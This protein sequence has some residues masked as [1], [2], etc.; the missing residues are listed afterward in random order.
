MKI[1]DRYIKR[2]WFIHALINMAIIIVAFGA[3]MVGFGAF[4]VD[5]DKRSLEKHLTSYAKT[6]SETPMDTLLAVCDGSYTTA[7]TEFDNPGIMFAVYAARENGSFALYTK[8]DFISKTQPVLGGYVNDI[9]EET[10]SGH[11]LLTYTVSIAGSENS[12]VKVFASNEYI[13]ESVALIKRYAIPFAVGFVVLSIAM[14]LVWG[15]LEIK[16]V[17]TNYYKQKDLISDISHE[18]RT[19]LAIIKGNLENVIAVPESSVSDIYETL[20]SCLQEVD[21]MN[22]VSS[23]LLDIVRGE[24][25]SSKKDAVLSDTL[26]E[27]IDIY[28]DAVSMSN[29]SLV[30]S[31]EQCNIQIDREKTRQLITILL[32]NSVKYTREGDRISVKLKN[33][34]DGCLLSVADT[35]IGVAANELESIFD[36]F[37]RAENTKSIQGTGLGLSIAKSIVESMNGTIRAVQ[38]I[39]SGLEIIVHLKRS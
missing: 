34:K 8:Y 20:E 17:I 25:K 9:S 15:Y 32:E 4:S 23:G 24:N 36:R 38:N 27:V 2:R 11:S 3:L 19:P 29:K 22:D 21:Y 16:P 35:G 26:S 30:A 12:F 7:G 31:I 10:L 13:N 18:I 5:S 33:V 1:I 6:L 28:S 14:S 39:P 37:Y